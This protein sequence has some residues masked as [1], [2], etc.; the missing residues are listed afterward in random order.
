LGHALPP[1][2]RHPEALRRWTKSYCDPWK[3]LAASDDASAARFVAVCRSHAMALKMIYSTAV[4]AER[5][6]DT[7]ALRFCVVNAVH[8]FKQNAAPGDDPYVVKFLETVFALSIP[9]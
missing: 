9:K 3:E 5:A 2:K 6:R 8:L 7:E 4:A 1:G